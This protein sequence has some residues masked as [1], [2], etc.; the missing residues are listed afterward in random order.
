MSLNVFAIEEKER[1]SKKNI[2][3]SSEVLYISTTKNKY[4][5]GLVNGFI[6]FKN[7]GEV[8]FREYTPNGVSI[9]EVLDDGTSVALVGSGK[10]FWEHK[11]SVSKD[12][13][14]VNKDIGLDKNKIFLWDCKN[15]KEIRKIECKQEIRGLRVH[16]DYL[17]V[18]MI[19]NV[20][21]YTMSGKFVQIFK[22]YNNPT[23]MCAI[24]HNKKTL[25]AFPDTDKGV[26]QVVNLNVMDYETYKAHDNDIEMI[27]LSNDGTY[28]ATASSKGTIIRVVELAK[29]NLVRELRRGSQPTT[30]YSLSFNSNNENLLCS[31]S[32]GTVHLF[33]LKKESVVNDLLE[34]LNL[35]VE[36]SVG[37][38]RNV[39][40]KY[41]C[42]FYDEKEFPYL[43]T[44]ITS[45]GDFTVLNFKDPSKPHEEEKTKFL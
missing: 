31:G 37:K 32:S 45:N 10:E 22:S 8:L 24:S 27:C 19:D 11:S 15:R 34:S 14:N 33:D 25:L 6:L 7:D 5:V 21:I 13:K 38:Y 3:S 30:I 40:G 18:V 1:N 16:K 12:T 9:I 39:K 36:K 41:V 4:S 29:G 17:A 42:T 44:C 43:V 23:G 35:T 2:K 28:M 20:S 26:V